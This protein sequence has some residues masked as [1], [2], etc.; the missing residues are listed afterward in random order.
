MA[1]RWI[2]KRCSVGRSKGRG[3]QGLSCGFGARSNAPDQSAQTESFRGMKSQPEEERVAWG[4]SHWPEPILQSRHVPERG[5]HEPGSIDPVLNASSRLGGWNRRRPGNCSGARAVLSGWARKMRAKAGTTIL[6]VR[7]LRS[8]SLVQSV[9]HL[10]H[11]PAD[12]ELIPAAL[13]QP[14]NDWGELAAIV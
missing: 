14:H 13:E 7:I 3:G 11:T 4:R 10:I 9:L 1:I 2:G 6:L 8:S 5:V 12:T